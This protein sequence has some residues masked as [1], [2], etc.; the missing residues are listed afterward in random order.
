MNIENNIFRGY[1]PD[2]N[3]LKDYG[4]LFSGNTGHFEKLFKDNLFKA[5]IKISSDGIITGSVYDTENK[6]EFLPLRL[7]CS[8]GAFVNEIRTE[9]ENILSDIRNKCYQKTYFVYAQSNRI[10][11]KINKKYGSRPEFLWDKFKGSGI[12]RN[13]ASKKWYAA[14]LDTSGTKFELET[15]ETVE[16]INLKL[17]PNHTEKLLRQKGF[18][19]AYHMNKKYWISVI[20]NETVN[21]DFIM[22]LVE[23]SYRCTLK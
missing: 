3:K 2:F 4:F 9:Y 11:E 21:D 8:K 10:T 18:Y 16:V 12:F 23:E 5:I 14:I 13:P 6:G 1:I 19:P 7:E 15:D 22:N 17:S 20:L